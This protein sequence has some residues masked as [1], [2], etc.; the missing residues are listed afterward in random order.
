MEEAERG[1]GDRVV[2]L[3]LSRSF[4]HRF[5]SFMFTALIFTVAAERNVES[6]PTQPPPFALLGTVNG[7]I[8]DGL[9]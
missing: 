6:C 9:K 1:G 3:S 8:K 4:L 5:I 7:G 2:S